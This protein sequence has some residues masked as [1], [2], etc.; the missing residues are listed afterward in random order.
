MLFNNVEYGSGKVY[1]LA[2][3]GVRA[4]SGIA[5]FGLADVDGSGGVVVAGT[6][7]M[8][9][10]DNGEGSAYSCA[11][12]PIVSLRSGVTNEQCSKTTD[13]TEAEWNYGGESGGGILD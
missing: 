6:Y 8:F 1:W 2:S 13:K 10:S 12:R 3:V 4:D 5:C 7:N 9:N 11:V